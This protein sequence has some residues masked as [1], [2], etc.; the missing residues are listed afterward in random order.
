MSTWKEKARQKDSQARH[1]ATRVAELEGEVARLRANL[2]GHH[3]STCCA[4]F[5]ELASLGCI[6]DME[7]TYLGENH[8]FDRDDMAQWRWNNCSEDDEIG[9]H[10]FG[11]LLAL[12]RSARASG[13]QPP[14]TTGDQP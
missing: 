12:V 1:L 10:T 8:A 14:P 6:D 5:E 7:I 3:A 13:S 2:P 4:A 11:Q 9:A